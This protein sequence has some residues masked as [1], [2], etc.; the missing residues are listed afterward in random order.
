MKDHVHNVGHCDRCKTVVEPRLSTQ[1]FIKIQPLADKAI[2]AVK[3]DAKGNKAIRFVPE[4]YEKTYLNWMENIHDWCISRQL[5]W[6][7]RIPAWHCAV[8]HKITVAR[9][10]PT[11]AR[12]AARDEI[13]QET[14]VLDT[15]FSSGLLPVKRVRVAEHHG[16]ERA[17]LRHVLSDQ[18][19]G[20]G[21]RHP[22]LLGGADDHAGV[23]VL[24]RRADGGWVERP[25]AENRVPFRE[26]YIHALVRDAN[27][28]KMSKTK[29]NVVDPIE[30]VKQYG[31]DAVRFTLAGDGFAGDGHCVQ[32]GA[33]GGLSRVRQQDLER[34]AVP[35]HER[36]S[37]G[38][39][40][41]RRG[42]CVRWARCRCAGADAPLE[43]RWIVA[44]LHADRGEGEP[45]A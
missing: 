11:S 2:A 1:W 7:H 38:G 18:P 6:G 45:G 9:E 30:I 17:R 21:L 27:R 28:E 29:G 23:L 22:V 16:G 34:G 40:R 10:D 42:S 39:D 8:C 5:W 20:D 14:D 25:A 26:V 13:T 41:D 19:A 44:E 35:V 15:W 32:R 4:M 36:G 3:P 43:A 12:I 31:T 37:G 24:G 33:D